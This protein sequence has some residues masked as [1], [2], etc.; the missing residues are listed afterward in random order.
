M[1]TVPTH[2]T[3]HL[4]PPASP[5][6][7][8]VVPYTRY[9]K[10][11]SSSELYP[12]WPPEALKANIFAIQSFTLNR[13]YTEFYRSRGF[14]FDITNSPSYDQAFIS[15]REIFGSISSL[16]D[17]FFNRY[18]VRAE[19]VQ[20]LA[21]QY[22]SG[23]SGTCPGLSQ[24][25]ST[26]LALSGMTAL[27][28][29]RYYYGEDINVQTGTPEE[30][31]PSYPGVPLRLGSIGEEVRTI[32]REL[33]RI[34]VNYPAIPKVD[35]NLGIFNAATQRSVMEFQRIFNLT[36]DGI[37]GMATWYKLKYIFN[38][39]KGLTELHGEGLTESEINRA[40]SGEYRMGDADV[41][42]R[43][44][45]YYL[46]FFGKFIMEIP[47]VTVDGIFGPKT[48]A[49]VKAFQTYFGLPADGIVDRDTFNKMV[50]G[51]VE[52]IDTLP[53]GY[54]TF[55]PPLYPGYFITFGSSGDV[56][57]QLQMFLR[58]I[59]QYDSRVPLVEIDGDYGPQTQNAVRAIQ[60]ISGIVPVGDV[61]PL[62][63]T[64]I[65]GMYNEYR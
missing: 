26:S 56:V 18:I 9:I 12:T 11:V 22:C 37:V 53:K 31:I 52:I 54:M 10:T 7:N 39:V 64:A 4:G 63:W 40:F 17:N 43:I 46:D 6:A 13:V 2:I 55:T 5:A 58:T 30:N 36:V 49:A 60:E 24:W 29:L 16:V 38:S 65:T 14:D 27:E 15:G 34:S 19:Q 59:A 48:E 28:I 3:V 42:V 23:L 50:T 32:Q 33:N 47:R 62:T 45:Q 25:G 21:A 61:G 41:I 8:I 1:V 44:I 20:P 51:Y 57:L 35:V